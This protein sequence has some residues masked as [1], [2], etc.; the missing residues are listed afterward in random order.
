MTTLNAAQMRA[1]ELNLEQMERFESYRRHNPGVPVY[2][3]V[4]QFFETERGHD[5]EYNILLKIGA[6]L[7]PNSTEDLN[8]VVRF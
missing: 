2:T 7:A 3:L 6:L 1:F 4:H 5:F 8:L